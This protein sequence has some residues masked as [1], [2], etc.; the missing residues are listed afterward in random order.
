MGSYDL[1][2]PIYFAY[3]NGV[4]TWWGDDFIA[5]LGVP[6]YAPTNPY[7]YYAL[8]FWLSTGPVDLALVWA[9]AGKYFSWL[10]ADTKTIQKKFKK[11]YNDAN[12]KI[13][14]SAFGATEFPTT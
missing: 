7:N 13:M 1:P 9:E 12:K 8:S 10:G 5:G 14:I 3:A 6:G 11:M 4:K 2:Y